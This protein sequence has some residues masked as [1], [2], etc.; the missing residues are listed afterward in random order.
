MLGACS[1]G[2]GS[3]DT[4]A[5]GGAAK[6]QS[7]KGS[8]TRPLKSPTSFDE[9]PMLAERVKAGD[10]PKV[11]E[12]LPAEP[13]VVPHRWLQPAK[14][15]GNLLLMSPATNDLQIREYMYGHSL[16]RFINDG[17]DIAPGLVSSWESNADASEWTLHFREGLKWSDGQP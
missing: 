4:P 15:G 2:G 7:G 3:E 17:L 6:A 12:R 10:L 9:A 13:Y 14:Y 8:E 16:L 1:S 11:A 5:A